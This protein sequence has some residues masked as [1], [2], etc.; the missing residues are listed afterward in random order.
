M[1]Q[2]GILDD[3]IDCYKFN[4][5]VNIYLKTRYSLVGNRNGSAGSQHCDLDPR[6]NR[7]RGLESG[8]KKSRSYEEDRRNRRS[9]ILSSG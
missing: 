4:L 5:S 3:K 1:M 6:V 8:V 7:K 2:C 9:D